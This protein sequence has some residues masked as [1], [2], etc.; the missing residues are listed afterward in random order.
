MCSYCWRILVFGWK[1]KLSGVSTGAL[2]R[3]N[4]LTG[5]GWPG[6]GKSTVFWEMPLR[7]SAAVFPLGSQLA[8]S[9]Q[10]YAE[11]KIDPLRT[12]FFF[13]VYNPVWTEPTPPYIPVSYTHLTLPTKA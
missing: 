6:G 1:R 13:Q 4:S 2:C 12:C 9:C 8:A 10:V 7:A 5:D 3:R 11:N